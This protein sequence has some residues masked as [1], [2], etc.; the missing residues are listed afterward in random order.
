MLAASAAGRFGAAP[1]CRAGSAAAWRSARKRPACAAAGCG[2]APRGGAGRA[3][4][5]RRGGAGARARAGH[6][7]AGARVRRA[8]RAGGAGTRAR[9][10]APRP[11][12]CH[13]TPSSSPQSC[14]QRCRRGRL[15]APPA[16]IRHRKAVLLPDA[17]ADSHPWSVPAPASTSALLPQRPL[18]CLAGDWQ[19]PSFDGNMTREPG[20]QSVR[21]PSAGAAPGRARGGAGRGPVRAGGGQGGG[22]GR[23]SGGWAAAPGAGGAGT[24]RAGTGGG[25][26]G[27]GGCGGGRGA[28][29]CGAARRCWVSAKHLSHARPL[30]TGCV[31]GPAEGAVSAG[32]A[33]LT[34]PIETLA[35]MSVSRFK[36]VW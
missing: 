10:P 9:A 21:R 29:G 33:R 12:P 14:L 1:R 35:E 16:P 3:Q 6:R 26:G 23:S 28:G 25:R 18:P 30:Q 34:A 7:R 32:R 8:G 4:A 2:A 17:G 20:I 11:I 22:R 13:R 19:Y 24:S 15:S 31:F 27:R 36:I 5:R